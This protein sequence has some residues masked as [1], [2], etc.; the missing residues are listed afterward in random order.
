MEVLM[1]QHLVSHSRRFTSRFNT[2]EGVWVYW[3]A[4]GRE[5]IARVRNLSLG[6]L[7]IETSASK[8]V[9]SAMKLDFL[10][11]EGQIRAD[12]VVRRAEP[13]RGL[14]L[15]FTEMTDADRSR[16]TALVNRLRQ[17]TRSPV[18]LL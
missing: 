14:A 5:D 12:A 7:F 1:L 6:G 2:P 8:K 15:K 10:V 13:S 17:T 16:L 18:S 9:D 4:D 11:Q 3:S